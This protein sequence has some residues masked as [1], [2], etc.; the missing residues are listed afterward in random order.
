MPYQNPTP[1]DPLNIMDELNNLVLENDYQEICV[2]CQDVL[3]NGEEQIYRLPECSHGYHTNC[4]MT[5]FKTCHN[6]KCPL[7]MTYF[8]FTLDKSILFFLSN[9]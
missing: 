7:C 6:T 8:N 1:V 2:I 4:I 5:W 3:D 9:K